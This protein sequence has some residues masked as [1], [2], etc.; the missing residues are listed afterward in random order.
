MK[1]MTDAAAVLYTVTL[2]YD[3]CRYILLSLPELL[4]VDSRGG[5]FE[6]VSC[7]LFRNTF[8]GGRSSNIHQHPRVLPPFRSAPSIISNGS[9]HQ[10]TPRSAPLCASSATVLFINGS[11][12]SQ[13]FPNSE[14]RK[15]VEICRLTPFCPNTKKHLPHL[16]LH[17]QA[18]TLGVP[19]FILG[20][21]GSNCRNSCPYYK[22]CISSKI[23]IGQSVIQPQEPCRTWVQIQA[24]S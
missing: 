1:S 5:C 6:T 17:L 4:E 18:W 23:V 2:K 20:L 9:V 11:S 22:P 15:T 3:E 7:P 21:F 19:R 8:G 10:P 13:N 24:D 14:C 12:Q 16:Q